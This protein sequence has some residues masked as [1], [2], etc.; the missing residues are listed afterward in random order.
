MKTLISIKGLQRKILKFLNSSFSNN[1]TNWD[2]FILG[3]KTKFCNKT[4]KDFFQ[5][6]QIA[7]KIYFSLTI[8]KSK[9]VE[10]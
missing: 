8:Y 4:G 2:Y 3:E 6:E 1:S 9:N 7:L 5:F 10:N